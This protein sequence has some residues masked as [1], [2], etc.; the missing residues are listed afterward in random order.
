MA[1][2]AV[3]FD[4]DGVLLELTR[5]EEDVFFQVFENRYGLKNLTRDWNSYQIRN[6]EN[7]VEEILLKNDIPPTDKNAVIAD[8]DSL[9]R[10]RLRDS[11]Q[12]VVVSG[13]A[14]LLEKIQADIKLGIATANFLSA[15]KAR[16][17]QVNLWSFVSAHAFGA[18]GGG[19]KRQTVARA[20]ASLELPKSR[21]VYVGDNVNDVDAGLSNDV[22]FIGFSTDPKRLRELKAAGA[23]HTS[24]NHL[25]TRLRIGHLLDLKL[26]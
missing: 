23:V 18:D 2:A 11:L 15:A 12:T 13:A 6:D 8:Y 3:I 26:N 10:E 16:L 1:D 4:V 24:D 22:H 19:H 7:I 9:I 14:E 5:E 17:Q 20:I 21:I 25:E